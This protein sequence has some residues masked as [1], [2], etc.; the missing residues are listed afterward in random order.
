MYYQECENLAYKHPDLRKVIEQI[1]TK[2]HTISPSANLNSKIIAKKINERE[3][4]VSGIFEL[5]CED[6]YQ[7]LYKQ[8]YIK[9]P[10]CETLNDFNDYE[11]AIDN[12]EIIECSYCDKD[13]I[14]SSPKEIEA[15]RLNPGKI[16]MNEEDKSKSK[17]ESETERPSMKFNQKLPPE[18]IQNPFENTPLMYY[19]SREPEWEK[20]KPFGGKRVFFVLHFLKD[21]IP[22]VSACE[23]LGLDLKNSYFFYKEY[24]YP[25]REAIGN[26]LEKKGAIVKPRS[27]IK[28]YLKQLAE[29]PPEHIGEILIIEDGGFIV[30]LIHNEFPKLINN[31]IGAVEQ[32]T[33]GIRNDE[34][35][36]LKFPVI[37][38]ATSDL[39]N[40]FEP[41][42]ISEAVVNNVKKLL[43]QISLRG[44]DIALFG[45]GAIG[46]ELANRLR[47]NG[48]NVT[49]YEPSDNNRLWAHQNGFTLSNSP[50]DAVLNKNF[51][52][53]ASGNESIDSNVI[54]NLSHN[55]YLVSASSELYEIDIEELSRRSKEQEPLM[56]GIDVIG[57]SFIDLKGN[58]IN[59]LANGYPINFWGFES[60][61]EEASDLIMGLILLSAA[62]LALRNYSKPTI[63]S[64]AVN[65]IAEKH[66][67]A[68][69]FLNHQ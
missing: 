4:Q 46:K 42:Y 45:C 18:F 7:L 2:L 59:V 62:E 30:P 14:K 9:C 37:S 69:K 1:D 55:T 34:K 64:E 61:P 56:N 50:R 43:P 15:Y 8:K 40:E 6:E 57:K 38:V 10:Y 22:F 51:V 12:E 27:N 39:K 49:I 60:M 25:Q 3:S 67:I 53:G 24:P 58:K 35:V 13:L 36:K 28:Y 17:N 68:R 33:R 31:V 29:S 66:D 47:S 23:S 20:S 26:W 44:K 19:F 48:S 5:L 11:K 41:K 16:I 63:N 32:T 21:L 65:Q 54:P 52:I